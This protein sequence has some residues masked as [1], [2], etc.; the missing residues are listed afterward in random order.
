VSEFTN[1]INVRRQQQPT[2]SKV[3]VKEG[4]TTKAGCSSPFHRPSGVARILRQEG[5]GMHVREIRQ[6]KFPHSLTIMTL[7]QL[8]ATANLWLEQENVRCS[9]AV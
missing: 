7:C 3:K 2:E 5:H 1:T 8:K 9:L 6:L 4:H